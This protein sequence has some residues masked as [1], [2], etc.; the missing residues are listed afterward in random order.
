MSDDDHHDCDHGHHGNDCNTATPIKH[1]IVIVGENS[2]FDHLS[3]TYVPKPGERVNNLL[4]EGIVDADG[5]P[6]A[7][8]SRATHFQ[9]DI[10]GSPSSDLGQPASFFV[11]S[12]ER[13]NR[14]P[15]FGGTENS[16]QRVV[17]AQHIV[18]VTSV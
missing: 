9:A 16:L 17:A 3:A 2:S 4:S 1:V 10:T 18:E 13:G 8:Y 11:D 6:G 15:F 14:R 7:N 5:T 12:F